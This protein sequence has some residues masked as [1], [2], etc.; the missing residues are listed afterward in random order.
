VCGL[1]VCVCVCMYICVCIYIRIYHLSIYVCVSVCSSSLLT[2][3]TTVTCTILY[4]RN[5]CSPLLWSSSI[6]WWIVSSSLTR[7][8]VC[9]T[10]LFWLCIPPVVYVTLILCLHYVRVTLFSEKKKGDFQFFFRKMTWR[11]PRV[12]PD[13]RRQTSSPPHLT[14]WRQT[15]QTT[16]KVLCC[17]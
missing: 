10:W 2:W 13:V 4:V 7:L 17:W 1:C 11:Q 8:S 5:T 3:R 12:R 16:T 9:L 14:V 15:R 6:S